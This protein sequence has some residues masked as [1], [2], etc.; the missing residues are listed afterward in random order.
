MPGDIVKVAPGPRTQITPPLSV[1]ATIKNLDT[2]NTVWISS[3][4]NVIPGNGYQLTAL[5]TMRWTSDKR[6]VWACVDTGVITPILL[7]I[8]DDADQT[9]DPVATGAAIATELLASGVRVK[10][11]A[12]ILTPIF[13]GPPIYEFD[14]SNY[15]SVVM[16]VGNTGGGTQYHGYVYVFLD[17]DLNYIFSQFVSGGQQGGLTNTNIVVPVLG[18]ILEIQITPGLPSPNWFVQ[19]EGLSALVAQQWQDNTVG[20]QDVSVTQTYV[21]ATPTYILTTQGN[22]RRCTGMV[23]HGSGYAGDFVLWARQQDQA[24]SQHTMW[25]LDNTKMAVSTGNRIGYFDII[26]PLGQLDWWVRFATA[27]GSILVTLS[28]EVE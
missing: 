3:N 8:S 4:P 26:H 6:Q 15:Q 25:V 13:N 7:N 21:A 24:L 2:V 12:D 1:G 10:N 5:G 11:Q 19:V 16:R 22:G 17:N 23:T 18:P 9:T 14:V 28:L 27:P 20:M